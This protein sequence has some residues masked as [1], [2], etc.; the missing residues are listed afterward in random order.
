MRITSN[1]IVKTYIGLTLSSTLATS[2]IWG[3]NTLFLL[4]AGLN[5]LQ[6]FAANAFFT[7]GQV[8][9]EVPTG[10][11]ADLWGRRTSYLLG[12]ITLF[13]STLLYLLLWQTQAP[14]WQWAGASAL[15][16]LGF[17]FFSGATEAWLVDA[18]D[19][20]G[21]KKSLETVFAKGQIA[22]GAAM[23]GGTL[24]GG[25]L[26]Q[27]FD[28][29]APYL[30]RALILVVTFLVAFVY[31]RDLGFSPEKNIKAADK[32]K[33]IFGESLKHGF[34]NP[35]VRWVM[36]AAPFTAG[37][38]YYG[39]YAMQ[40]YLLELYGDPNAYFIAGLGASILA[41]SLVAG[42][43]LA[44]KIRKLFRR[45]T[46][47]LITGIV[48]NIAL[49]A[50]IGIFSSFWIVLGLMWLWGLVYAMSGPVR[51]A[52]INDLIPSEQRATVLSFDNLVSS[53]GGIASQ[54][55]LGRAADIYSYATSYMIAAVM[56]IG[57]LPF[58][59]LAKKLNAK[60]DRIK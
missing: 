1:H 21:Y 4:D 53:T 22:F 5:N 36:L 23:I 11:V 55:I 12:S 50:A 38:S 27:F 35:P 60:S 49:L 26:A 15:L 43:V 7:I 9:F 17:T 2:L 48:L 39:F 37:V 51:Q 25:I 58:T 42:G 24:A 32:I 59:L 45:R 3:V 30:A 14:F 16:G 6:A 41:G 8:I 29:G 54:P 18:L 52:Y 33:S 28:L 31:M 56:G 46:D 19:F 13:L 44:P 10:I 20:T 57:A 34:G 40:P 47:L